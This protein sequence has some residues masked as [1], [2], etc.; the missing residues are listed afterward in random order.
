[1]LR[2]LGRLLLVLVL[3]LALLLAPVAYN[4]LACTAPTDSED[5]A[6]ILPPEQHRAEARTLLTYPEWHIVHAYDDYARV[7]GDGDPHDYAFLP[8]ITGYWSSLCAL[9]TAA[10]EHGGMDT[11][12]KQLVYTIGVSFTAELL[13][14]AAYEETL[15]RLF[16]SLRG[17]EPAPLDRLTA[18]QA[19]EYA[20]FLQQVPWYKWDF[21]G[22][23]VALSENATDALR[24][25][26]RSLA[27]GL[28]YRFKSA[29]AGLIAQAVES[30]GA[31]ALRLQMVVTGLEAEALA[32]L[33]DVQVIREEDAGLVIETPRYRALTRLLERMA[34]E[35]ADFVEIAGNDDVLY[36][37]VSVFPQADGALFSFDRQGYGDTRHLFLTKVTRLADDLRAM[38]GRQM[39][40]EHVHDY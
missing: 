30:V 18:Q 24:D 36:T 8:A 37:A 32:A 10:A 6:A 38:E 21:D 12:A 35:G 17:P 11:G 22:A 40:L 16:A 27:V 5:Y 39:T 25:R 15:G 3:G 7:I 4:D 13:A 31:D 2:W 20:Q 14:K 28:E 33:P 34:A 9:T 23:A 19:A 29:Y 26:E 1:M